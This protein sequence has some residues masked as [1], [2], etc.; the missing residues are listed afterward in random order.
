M[1]ALQAAAACCAFDTMSRAKSD[2]SLHEE[3]PE[4][5]HRHL[6]EKL[7]AMNQSILRRDEDH[8]D[9]LQLFRHGDGDAV[10]VHAIGSAL[11][12]E[13]ERGN[14][15]HDTLRQQR[16][17]QVNVHALDLAGEEVIHAVNDAHRMC[18]DHVRAGGA[19][20]VADRPS[21]ISWVSRLAAV[22][23]SSSV[24]ASVT[25]VPSTSE[26]ETPSF[27]ASDVI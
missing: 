1:P 23:A 2:W 16:L 14:D 13:S 24:E 6:P 20:I 12:V 4:L 27:S 17:E 8:F 7:T 25:P 9:R 10:G 22:I 5:L 26:T 3:P 15:R 18:R 11:A 19:Q 21:R